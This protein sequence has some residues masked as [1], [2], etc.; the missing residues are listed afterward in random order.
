MKG[1]WAINDELGPGVRAAFGC[2]FEHEDYPVGTGYW[3]KTRAFVYFNA[4][5]VEQNPDGPGCLMHEIAIVDAG[6][7]IPASIMKKATPMDTTM[8]FDIWLDYLKK[9]NK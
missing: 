1:F 7:S 4:M 6:G 8:N 9:L 5:I 2:S 3:D